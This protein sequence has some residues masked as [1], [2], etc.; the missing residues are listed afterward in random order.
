MT[1]GTDDSSQP[2]APPVAPPAAEPD[3]NPFQRI[4]GVLFA[5]VRTFAEIARRPDI[6]VPLVLIIVIGYASTIAIMPRIDWDTVM[7]QQFAQARKANPNMSDEDFQRMSK[8]GMAMGKGIAYVQPLLAVI[9]YVIVAGVLLLGV[10]MFGGEG[11][12]QQAFSV[13]LYAWFPLILYG[14]LTTIVV[15]AKGTFDPTH[16][17]TL[18]KSNPA[19]LID[20]KQHFVLYS[21]LSMLDVFTF[22]MLALLIIGFASVSKFSKA[23][24]AAV[25]IP[26]WLL[27]VLIRLGFAAMGAARMK[28]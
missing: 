20:M 3:V 18:V 22:W 12:F 17:A 19:F 21:L 16:V 2:A 5:P 15:V 27:L 7:D 8:F 28:G 25:V 10:R 26:A 6:L 24:A 11:N 23:K 1:T 4:A 13:T 9:W 14:I